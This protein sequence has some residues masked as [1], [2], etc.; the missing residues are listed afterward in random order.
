MSARKIVFTGG[1]TGGHV[2]PAIAIIEQLKKVA[3]DLEILWIGQKQG[4][5]KSMV[6]KEQIRYRGI[7]AGKF[8]RYFSLQNFL[9]IFKIVAGFF[10]AWFI[11]LQE[12][13]QLIFSKG[14]FVTVPVVWAGALLRI[15]AFI[16]ESDSDSGL[17]NRLTCHVA[18]RIFVP[19]EQ[20]IKTFPAAVRTKISVS[21]NPIRESF[22]HANASAA[23][24]KYHLKE[25]QPFI[26]VLGGSLGSQQVNELVHS[27]LPRL[28]E[29]CFVLHQMGDKLY[30]ESHRKNYVT[31][32]FIHND[33]PDCISASTFVIARS[34]AGSVWEL[35]MLGAVP[36]FIPLGQRGDQ[37][38]NA[39]VLE[40][41]GACISLPGDKA[42]VDNLAAATLQLLSDAGMRQAMRQAILSIVKGNSS[43]YLAQQIIEATT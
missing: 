20:T 5:E 18:Q 15:P 27:L 3:P 42:T 24:A 38:R 29:D 16:H 1:G 13:P 12:K 40:K 43:I 6:E 39:A 31:V 33:L 8:R 2:Y 19:Y 30:E 28:P 36:I 32:P 37:V 10:Q 34:G 21:G 17:A 7:S 23:R 4:I 25:D 35:A 22:W 11:L 9:D 14:G 41:I 26:L